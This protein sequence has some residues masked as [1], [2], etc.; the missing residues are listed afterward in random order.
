[1]GAFQ[2]C[3]VFFGAPNVYPPVGR[4]KP[5]EISLSCKNGGPNR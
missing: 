3:N 5:K 2:N 1:M 4:A